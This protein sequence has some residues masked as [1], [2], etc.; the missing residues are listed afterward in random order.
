MNR[1]QK[2]SHYLSEWIDYTI[3]DETNIDRISDH[4]LFN[5]TKHLKINPLEHGYKNEMDFIIVEYLKSLREENMIDI[6]KFKEMLR[7]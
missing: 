7:D 3:K 4:R 6:D 2:Y 5:S 1:I